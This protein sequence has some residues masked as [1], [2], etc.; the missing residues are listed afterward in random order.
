M[1]KRISAILKNTGFLYIRLL[2][3]MF[4][5]FYTSRVI[6]QVLGV[7]D[8][9]VYSV[10][11][12]VT[13]TFISL[14]SV[15]SEAVLRYLNYE[16]GKG[17]IGNERIVFNLSIIIH[18]IVAVV[19]FI[20]VEIIGLWLI[21]NKLNIPYDRFDTAIFVFH[22]SVLSSTIMIFTIPY[23]AVII[24]N[25]KINIYALVAIFDA[26]LRLAVILIVP[27]LQ[28][29]Y[30]KSYS[31][32]L[33]LIPISTLLIYFF[34]CKRFPECKISSKFDK[35]LFKDIA[36]YSSWN[37]LGN[38]IFSIVHEALNM[39]LNIYGGVIENAARNIAYQVKNVVNNFSNN[40]LIAVKPYVI[41][42]SAVNGNEILFRQTIILSKLAYYLS[43]IISLPLILYCEQLL[44][45]WLPEVPDNAVIFTQLAII[46]ILIRSLH[47]PLSLMYMSVGRIKFMTITE[48]LVF[49]SSLFV[50]WVL[51]SNNF[52]LWTVFVVLC[53]TEFI[54]II[55]LSINAK[56]ELSFPLQSYSLA[57]IRLC[58]LSIC[59]F[60][61]AYLLRTVYVPSG[62]FDLFC[63]CILEVI[64]AFIVIYL[65]LEKNEKEICRK[66]I[67]KFTNKF[68]KQ[69]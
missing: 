45:I 37:F 53:L 11:G 14:R 21:N 57:L 18:I 58:A 23:D 48:G 63:G 64:L 42:S 68:I 46:A 28:F 2:L 13:A 69:R 24:S 65:F 52:H 61:L 39:M 60:T 49:I 35:K 27:F 36:S 6:L 8:F 34:Y 32:M 4:L 15:F 59:V 29:D 30:L 40:A 9:G 22:M 12:S 66:I 31:V 55:T 47:G 1:N 44:D 38:F 17:N 5:S 41:Q 54:T 56:F 50:S 16:K 25:E 19:F 51:L 20:V 62:L 33:L 26:L 67:I 3:T 43:L 10:V 7:A